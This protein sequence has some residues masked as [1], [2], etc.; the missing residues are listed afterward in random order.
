MEKKTTLVPLI[1]NMTLTKS[2]TLQLF[3]VSQAKDQVFGFAPLRCLQEAQAVMR[4]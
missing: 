1:C 3:T 4:I 2:T